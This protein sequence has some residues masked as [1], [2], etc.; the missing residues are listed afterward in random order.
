[1]QQDVHVVGVEVRHVVL[2]ADALPPV[3]A[4][5]AATGQVVGGGQLGGPRLGTAEVASV[6]T[7]IGYR[8]AGEMPHISLR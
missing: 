1:M 6:Y 2:A 4:G 7:R 8:T 5:A 3:A